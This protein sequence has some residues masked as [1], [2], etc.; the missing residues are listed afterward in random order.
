V[1]AVATS[2]PSRRMSMSAWTMSTN[3]ALKFPWIVMVLPG[4][5]C[6]GA[7][8]VSTA[9]V[10]VATPAMLGSEATIRRHASGIAGRTLCPGTS[11]E[12]GVPM[13]P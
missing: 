6:V 1:I 7:S 5:A 8:S 11:M 2:A 4:P 10:S 3:D 12:K 13:R 9:G